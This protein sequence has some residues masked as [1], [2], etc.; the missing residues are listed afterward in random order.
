[1]PGDHP[2]RATIAERLRPSTHAHDVELT[3]KHE[4]NRLLA[5]PELQHDVLGLIAASGG[6][7]TLPD[8]EE[9][10]RHPRFAVEQLLSGP[11]GRTIG[12]RRSSQQRGEGA[13]ERVYLFAH[14]TLHELADQQFGAT[15]DRYRR[16][17]HDWAD[18][19]RLEGWPVG[20]PTY[21][22]RGYT[23]M[24]VATENIDRLVV[25]ATDRQ[26]RDRMLDLSGGDGLSLAEL[27]S[28]T[29]L[30]AHRAAPDLTALL[31]LA[32]A[33]AELA[34]RNASLPANLPAAW[35]LLDQP[36]RA[37][38][39]A[40]GVPTRRRR[41]A[42][43]GVATALAAAGDQ[44]RADALAAGVE[45]EP[46]VDGGALVARAEE[47]WAEV[48]AP[49]GPPEV[50][51]TDAALLDEIATRL[52]DSGVPEDQLVDWVRVAAAAELPELVR[53][54]AQQLYRRPVGRKKAVRRR[55]WNRVFTVA[56][57]A[58][59][60]A[61]KW[62]LSAEFAAKCRGKDARASALVAA[63]SCAA[64]QA[65]F[66]VAANL[67]ADSLTSVPLRHNEVSRPRSISTVAVL[68]AWAGELTLAH[69]LTGDLPTTALRQDAA[70]RVATIS[71]VR[72]SGQSV[73]QFLA[74]VSAN[75]SLEWPRERTAA[76]LAVLAA[77]HGRLSA[78][79]ELT[80]LLADEDLRSDA[81]M[82]VG[83][84]A[85]ADD[86]VDRAVT[87]AI[88]GPEAT[89][90]ERLT[91]VA[92]ALARH[93]DRAR[94]RS[95]LEEAEALARARAER[96]GVV[97]R[98][99][100]A[101]AEV[102]AEHGRVDLANEVL[103]RYGMRDDEMLGRVA[104]GAARDK[105][106]DA[107]RALVASIGNPWLTTEAYALA[108]QEL[109]TAGD[110]VAAAR[111]AHE[112]A[113][114]DWRRSWALARTAEAAARAGDRTV[115][116]R[117]WD[118]ADRRARDLVANDYRKDNAVGAVARAA[119]VV[120][121]WPSAADT[122]ATIANAHAHA[123]V[124]AELATAAAD[125][126][127]ADARHLL[128]EAEHLLGSAAPATKALA[129]AVTKAAA[130]VH[131]VARDWPALRDLLDRIPDLSTWVVVVATVVAAA[132][133]SVETRELLNRASD[134]TLS[135][136]VSEAVSASSCAKAALRLGDHQL[137]HRLV[138]AAL[139]SDQWWYALPALARLAP[140]AVVSATEEILRTAPESA[141]PS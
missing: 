24:L 25:C 54:L 91:A 105:Q 104:V 96:N 114:D 141:P 10:T 123:T 115:A 18:S 32:V 60:G 134:L 17:V 29:T 140:T 125:A 6:G 61:G 56:A 7:L 44:N 59:A 77:R 78:G 67:L 109:A 87:L 84:Y 101:L 5:G 45:P 136:P 86:D 124:L 68:A 117:L 89:R 75:A 98:S 106:V 94:A 31:L 9:L 112:I 126:D 19:Y 135:G 43:R 37:V 36:N 57:E 35:V 116:T 26:R 102:C 85:P 23:R 27:G 16:T 41:R 2:L 121:S 76:A 111:L 130:V 50:P 40:S 1:V 28:A 108:A 64:H 110:H 33:R 12:G 103:R 138:V 38:A 34:D 100:G 66:T 55:R 88:E 93:G 52:A 62:H 4:L 128:S 92:S 63:A 74:F 15:L 90:S 113:A 131:V 137:A 132:P 73:T 69:R 81:L 48:P 65:D 129:A 49:T 14:E 30:T 53:D 118:E 39:L 3:A 139:T 8:L 107:V 99:V 133:E 20:T 127:L 21:L 72:W 22:L 47:L 122:A 80:T 13:A 71:A 119:G 70:V 83:A 46:R 79:T 11:F 120:H 42:L 58:A 97:Y 51:A 95:L 82:A